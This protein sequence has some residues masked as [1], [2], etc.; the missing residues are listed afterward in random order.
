MNLIQKFTIQY[1]SS[2]ETRWLCTPENLRMLIRSL[3]FTAGV[4][5]T[6]GPQPSISV[7]IEEQ[8]EPLNPS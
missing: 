1:E 2:P 6:T 5:H 8:R 4:A 7:I 3:A